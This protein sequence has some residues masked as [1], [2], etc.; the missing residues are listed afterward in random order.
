MLLFLSIKGVTRG[1]FCFSWKFLSSS[2]SYKFTNTAYLAYADFLALF[3]IVLLKLETL[4]KTLFGSFWGLLNKF[5]NLLFFS[6][7]FIE[8]YKLFSLNQLH[9]Y[10]FLLFNYFFGLLRSKWFKL[11]STIFTFRSSNIV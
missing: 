1:K 6:S 10:I 5:C 11:K 3:E 7:L 2:F 9:L 8:F 4:W